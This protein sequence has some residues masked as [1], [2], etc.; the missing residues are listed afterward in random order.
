MKHEKRLDVQGLR[1]LAI[2]FVLGFHGHLGL[3]SGF[4]GVDVFFA[5]SGFVITTT[6][7][8]ELER[9]GS[10]SLP[11][12]Y[13]RRAKRLLPALAAMVALVVGLGVLLVPV[14]AVHM[15]PLTALA[16]SVFGGNIYLESLPRDYF[17]ASSNLDPLLHTW[18]LGVEEQFYLAFPVILLASWLLGR[19]L[20]FPRAA[21][22][23][24][25]AALTTGA[26]LLAETWNVSHPMPAR[27][28]PRRR[29]RGSSAPACSL[30]F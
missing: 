22:V 12:F 8:A 18:T 28:T 4:V 24:S 15:L 20:R 13:L 10:I 25:A 17:S 21:C 2:L 6:L 30:P 7:V 1:A 27:S 19:R 5:I 16:A 9:S 23:L 26:F 11:G 29:A 14:A 3:S